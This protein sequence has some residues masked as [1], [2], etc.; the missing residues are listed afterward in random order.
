MKPLSTKLFLIKIPGESPALFIFSRLG[1][2]YEYIRDIMNAERGGALVAD[3]KKIKAEYV[4]G[5]TSYRKLAAKHGVSPS[6][7]SKI[8]TREKWAELRKQ[9]GAKFDTKLTD[10]VARQEAKRADGINR[11]AD[12]L[13]RKIEDFIDNGDADGLIVTRGFRDL[14]GALKDLKD[15]RGT[16]SQLEIR[17]QL[18][19]ITKLEKDM[20]EADKENKVVVV[21]DND[22]K[23]EADEQ[24]NNH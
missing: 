5:G 8:A 13:L 11:V 10:S 3:W 18:A 7:L 9:T 6:T 12:K 21:F 24:N 19:R 15:V 20:Q 2:V 17:E 1:I 22:L 14:T 23:G 16:K 4:R